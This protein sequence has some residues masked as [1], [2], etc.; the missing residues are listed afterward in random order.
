MFLYVDYTVYL[1]LYIYIYYLFLYIDYTVYR[2]LYIYTYAEDFVPKIY[3]GL[4]FEIIWWQIIYYRRANY[5]H[6]LFKLQEKS[7][8][9]ELQRYTLKSAKH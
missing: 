3:L 4:I 7:H 5:K 6:Y 8:N 2:S 1:S 9:S